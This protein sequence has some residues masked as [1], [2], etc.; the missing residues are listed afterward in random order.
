MMSTAV[1]A[2][3][4][5][6]QQ[7]GTEGGLHLAWA[8]LFMRALAA[9]GV[10][11]VVVCPGSRSTPLAIAAAEQAALRM[12][13]IV[14][15]R[16][17]AFFALG[18]ARVTGRPT[19]LVCTSGTAAAHFL[20]A[21]IEASQA[22][23]PLLAV[24]ADRPWELQDASAS[25]TID[26]VEL[27]GGFVRHH[28][29]LGLPDA[30]PAAMHAVARVAAQA[31]HASM[32][33]TPGPVHVNARFRKPLEPVAQSVGEAG[34]EAA[35]RAALE[36]PPPRALSPSAVPD[37]AA[38]DELCARAARAERGLIVCGPAPLARADERRR[39][40][41]R[42]ARVTGFPLLAEATS[43]TRFG[44]PGGDGVV[45]CA[46]FDALL[47]SPAARARW[48]P[49]L[50]IEIGAPATSSAWG[51]FV[52]ARPDVPRWVLAPHGWNDPSSSATALVLGDPQ[53]AIEGL[54]QRLEDRRAADTAARGARWGADLAEAD[55]AVADAVQRELGCGQLTEGRVTR[56]LR[57]AC[58]AGA[59][60]AIGNSLPVRHLDAYCP[61]DARPLGVVHQ[62]GASGIDGLVSGAAGARSVSAAPLAL[63]LGDLS[64]LHDVGGL[65]AARATAGPLPMVVLHNDGG[66]IFEQLPIA[67]RID[68]AMLERCFTMPQPVELAHAAAL[69]GLPYA[70]VTTPGELAGALG[71]A[72]AADRPMLIEAVVEPGD[73]RRRAEALWR[74]ARATPSLHNQIMENG[75]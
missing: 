49:D 50:V 19:V 35:A 47:R 8:R 74:A 26:Q 39:A 24:T 48:A 42:L 15:E 37:Q 65:A 57:D 6:E 2:S 33:P 34:W 61:H 40:V 20:P 23:V 13:S 46:S 43:Q 53:A 41:A 66:R 28:A 17:A 22:F 71:R 4:L 45:T 72:F 7:L 64:L 75:S 55:R 60:L 3:P 1:S 38:L 10:T 31:V 44:V 29:E 56:M 58:P 59:L 21:V 73:A 30:S 36:R 25:Q 67:D 11:E 16:S 62:R 54:A 32:W 12:H 69:F 70:R 52:A 9:A 18:Q 14:D 27:F 63:L 5:V 68:A 51:A